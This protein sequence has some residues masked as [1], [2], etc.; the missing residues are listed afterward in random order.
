MAQFL[1]QTPVRTPAQAAWQ[2]FVDRVERGEITDP[3]G[4]YVAKTT[5]A[6]AASA[7]HRLARPKVDVLLRD[8]SKGYALRAGQR[9]ASGT[10]TN[11]ID[12]PCV[13]QDYDPC[14]PCYN[15]PG[16]CSG[17]G[18]YSTFTT[19]ENLG[20]SG[21]IHDLKLVEG[22]DNSTS[23]T[24]T[25]GAGY[26]KLYADLNKGAGGAYIYLC[27]Q[28]NASQVLNGVEYT[29]NS[30]YSGPN[31]VLTAFQTQYGSFTN[32]TPRPDPYFYSI[33]VP[34]QNPNVYWDRI[35][36]NAGAGG[37]YIYSFQAKNPVIS[38][39]RYIHEVGILSGNSSTITPP[40]G[41]EI[42]RRDLNNNAGGEYIYFCYR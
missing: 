31:E 32:S 20:G 41:W 4:Q 3:V 1:A 2:D 33:W 23:T 5:K 16:G 37:D 13:S 34:N 27:F 24:S 35:D 28:R 40:S 10:A 42:Y 14:G 21:Y 15:G 29:Y 36:L 7:G 17:G 18:V 12:E 8:A 9:A 19:S 22:D 6:P 38:N 30:P 26:T 25:V 39:Y 11:V